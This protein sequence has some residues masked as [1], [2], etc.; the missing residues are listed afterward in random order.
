MMV[1][2]GDSYSMDRSA[3]RDLQLQTRGRGTVNQHTARLD[4]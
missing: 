3:V 4:D 1:R 2:I